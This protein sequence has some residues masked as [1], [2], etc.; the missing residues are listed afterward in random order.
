MEIDNELRSYGNRKQLGKIIKH[1][2]HEYAKKDE[3]TRIENKHERVKN[4]IDTDTNLL[5]TGIDEYMFKMGKGLDL[6]RIAD[7][8]A[9]MYEKKMTDDSEFDLFLSPEALHKFRQANIKN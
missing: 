2:E 6:S 3:I 9:I 4:I 1:C 8:E 7:V 5:K